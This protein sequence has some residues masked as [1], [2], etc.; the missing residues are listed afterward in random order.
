MAVHLTPFDHCCCSISFSG[1]SAYNHQLPLSPTSN[2]LRG[3]ALTFSIFDYCPTSGFVAPIVNSLISSS[4][5]AGCQPL[6][7]ASH[8][9]MGDG[10]VV[11][12]RLRP[13]RLPI[14]LVSLVP[15]GGVES[16]T[17]GSSDQCSYHA[18]C[19]GILNWWEGRESNSPSQ[20][21]LIYSQP[22]YHLRYT[23]PNK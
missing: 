11:I 4:E 16:P 22:R 13:R 8:Y 17:P 1:S 5:T 15:A 9:R 7:L 14:Y 20:R 19:T 23:F 18:S 3:S 10:Q 12:Q 21:Q 6:R 2:R